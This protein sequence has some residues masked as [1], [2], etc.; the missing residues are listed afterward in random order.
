MN[1]FI[2]RDQT[3]LDL[4]LYL[5]VFEKY[6][7]PPEQAKPIQGSLND[8][9]KEVERIKP[10]EKVSTVKQK[11]LIQ[12]SLFLQSVKSTSK[13]SRNSICLRRILRSLS[14]YSKGQKR[15]RHQKKNYPILPQKYL[16][17]QKAIQ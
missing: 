13:D 4:N 7:I 12:S 14:K 10:E 8:L 9:S 17:I 1:P 11:I 6:N 15:W 2:C 3:P 5:Q 16:I